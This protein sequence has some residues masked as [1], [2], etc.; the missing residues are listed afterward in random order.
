MEQQATRWGLG[1]PT[2]RAGG[3]NDGREA[4]GANTP[5]EAGIAR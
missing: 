2:F 5:K 4:L 1:G 3:I